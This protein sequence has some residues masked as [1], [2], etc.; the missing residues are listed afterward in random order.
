MIFDH[1]MFDLMWLPTFFTNYNS[2]ATAAVKSWQKLGESFMFSDFR[3]A[4]HYIFAALFLV[5]TGISCTLSKN[6]L[7]RGLKLVLFAAVLTTATAFVDSVAQMDAL[8]V[9]GVIHCMA[10]GVLLYCLI[11]KLF[12][13]DYALLIIGAAFVIAGIS[14]PWYE[15]EFL[16]FLPKISDPD[17][18]KTM[19]DVVF[20]FAR[21]GSDHFGVFPGCGVILMGAYIGKCVYKNKKSLVPM[22]D[23]RWN[24]SFVWIGKRTAWVYLIHQP[25]VAGI[26]VILGM[27][28]GLEV[29]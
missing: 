3:T 17:F 19:V 11:D 7:L 28:N 15:M 13:S 6:N 12:K 1:F 14:I 9:F 25:V 5:L 26:I 21:G 29:L 10:V 23:G 16:D 20:G 24:A 8:I 4:C 27:L 2:A 22:L 18:L